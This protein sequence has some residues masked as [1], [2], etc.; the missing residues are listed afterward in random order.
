[1]IEEDEEEREQRVMAGLKESDEK[2]SER[3]QKMKFEA[4]LGS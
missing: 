4:E 1:M 3:R 2:V